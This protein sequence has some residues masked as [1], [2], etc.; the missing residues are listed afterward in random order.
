MDAT[1]AAVD[2]G[3]P[4]KIG[5]VSKY[6][7]KSSNTYAAADALRQFLDF[8]GVLVLVS[9]RGIGVSSDTL[10]LREIQY[11]ERQAR[12]RCLVSWS[13]CAVY[14]G[15]L[16][17]KQTKADTS[18]ANKSAAILWAVLL[19]VLAV[20]IGAA[21]FVFRRSRNRTAG[22]LNDLRGAAG[23]TLSLADSAVEEIEQARVSISAAVR[24]DYDRALA[25]RARAKSELEQGTT[26]PALT[27][28][29]QDAAAAVLALQ[30]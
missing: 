26:A 22:D 1:R 13:Q 4:E 5:L 29:N 18:A 20:I 16:A 8:A 28:A 25:L 12:P 9:P 11:V 27:Q 6:P 15:Q 17:V 21:V 7:S 3:V 24:A 10:T 14:A 23:Q 30:A 2:S 19:A